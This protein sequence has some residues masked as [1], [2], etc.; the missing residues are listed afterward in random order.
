M[1][2]TLGMILLLVALHAEAQFTFAG[3]K[4]SFGWEARTNG[5]AMR[6]YYRSGETT[7]SWKEMLTLQA[8][9]G[10]KTLADVT[11]PYYK[12][13]ESL[14]AVRPQLH[15]KKKGDLSDAVLELVLGKPK[16]TDSVE[17]VLARFIKTDD[18]AYAV[19]FCHRV[20]ISKKRNQ[21]VN[22]NF[23]D[24]DKERWLHDLFDVPV[25]KVRGEFKTG[26]RK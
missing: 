8:H 7:N 1:K 4:Y 9:P 16:K 17:F 5:A 20:P 2:K 11:G 6:E 12:A 21:D 19:I 10:V 24:K 3:D 25:E 23:T 14:V 22:L 26:G 15:L 18:G 13:R